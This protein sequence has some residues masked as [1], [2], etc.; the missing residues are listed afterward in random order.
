[1]KANQKKMKRW[2]EHSPTNY[3]HKYLLV[4]AETLSVSRADQSVK[5]AY[6][7]CI[8]A[9]ETNEY[10]NELA[11]C[12]ELAGRH[13]GQSGNEELQSYYMGKALKTYRKWGARAKANQ[14][15]DEF[16]YL[17]ERKDRSI[18]TSFSGGSFSYGSLSGNNLL[19]LASV[20]KAATTISSEIKLSRA[21]PTL[22]D[23]LTEN[24]GA[25]SGAFV[26]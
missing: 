6:D 12:Y 9:A 17:E 20:L 16:P 1:M 2:S 13:H 26:F 3:L 14:L 21:I 4:E 10:L 7:Q 11:L 15:K 19:D 18:H 22:L 8:K 25:Q 23:I 24:A 5:G